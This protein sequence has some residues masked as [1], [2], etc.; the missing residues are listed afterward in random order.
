[1]KDARRDHAKM[2]AKGIAKRLPSMRF[3][4]PARTGQTPDQKVRALAKA[5]AKRLRKRPRN[6]L[7]GGAA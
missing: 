3:I 7:K 4:L 5:S 2:S 1:M 6:A